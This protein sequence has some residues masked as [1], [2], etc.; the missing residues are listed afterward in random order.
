ME[1]LKK[2]IR[3]ESLRDPVALLALLAIVSLMGIPFTPDVVP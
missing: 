2:R 3:L 1:R